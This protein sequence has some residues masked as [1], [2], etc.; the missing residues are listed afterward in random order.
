MLENF[1]SLIHMPR[2]KRG[3]GHV[4][5]RK[6][7]LKHTK[8][9]KW[10]RKSKIRLAR[11]AMLK[12]GVYAYGD[13]RRRKRSFRAL[14]QIRINAAVRPLGL[15]YN[16]FIHALNKANSELDRKILALMAKDYPATFQKLVEQ[17]K[18]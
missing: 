18:G 3:V 6:N 11:P 15:N 13:R 14:W 9:M 12:A 2:V 8:G 4:K 16:Q 1:F 5:H 7:L 10:G 17:I